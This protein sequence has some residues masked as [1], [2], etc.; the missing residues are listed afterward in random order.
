MITNF[1]IVM[2]VGILILIGLGIWL[3]I[4]SKDLVSSYLK[5]D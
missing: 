2:M 3:I 5:T 4:T 1:D